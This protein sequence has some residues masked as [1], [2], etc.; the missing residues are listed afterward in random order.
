M[1]AFKFK[2]VYQTVNCP[3]FMKMRKLKKLENYK[4]FL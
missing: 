2:L 4:I 1:N 3:V